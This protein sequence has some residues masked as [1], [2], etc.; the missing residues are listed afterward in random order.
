MQEENKNNSEEDKLQESK[1]SAEPSVDKQEPKTGI[2]KLK[3]IGL[4]TVSNKTF[5][6]L[7]NL[8]YL[9]DKDFEKLHKT[10]ALGFIQILERD[11]D[12]DLA[13][14]KDD[15]LDF[16][17]GGR[18]KSKKKAKAKKEAIKEKKSLQTEDIPKESIAVSKPIERNKPS[19]KIKRKPMP[20]E[21]SGFK[22]GPYILIALAAL[23]GYYLFSSAT[24]EENQLEV[25][26][27]NVVQNDSITK[28][29]QENLL[30]TAIE[31]NSTNTTVEDEDIDLNKVVQEMFKEADL[32]ESEVANT[33]DTN[34]TTDTTIAKNST[35]DE[36]KTKE[37]TTSKIKEENVIDTEAIN[38]QTKV[39]VQ[40][41]ETKEAV[42]TEPVSV[43]KEPKKVVEKPE[44]VKTKPVAVANGLYIKPTKKAWVGVIYLDNF[45][46]K[47]YLI[48][49]K[50][51]LDKNR[52]QIIL[53][54]HKNFKIYSDGQQEHFNS[55]KMVRFIYEGGV[56]REISKKE[57][58]NRS[59]GTRW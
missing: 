15:Y 47:D 53:V 13:E 34:L 6:N 7:E 23:L 37:Q 26:D 33:A 43:S 22:I 52:D 46:K 56:L 57:Y 36:N 51:N 1:K 27:L 11:F 44:I 30:A 58:L 31:E 4:K 55:K 29:A 2:E 42:K 38:T 50:L 35:K 16:Q 9:L 49:G 25:L 28:K 21:E 3:D 10:K 5:I 54:G 14:L 8:T 17:S 40:K 32:N 18:L 20:T 19:K 39:T 24:K 12:V 45:S 48:R 59:E 41:A